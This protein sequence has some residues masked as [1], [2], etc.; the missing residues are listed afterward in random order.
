MDYSECETKVS[1]IIPVY[2][3]SKY[4]DKCLDSVLNQTYQNLEIVIVDDGSTDGSGAICDE[5]ALKDKRISVYHQDNKGVSSARNYALNIISG[6]YV[7]IID[8]DDY[9]SKNYVEAMLT[10]ALNNQLDFVCCGVYALEKE[11]GTCQFVKKSRDDQIKNRLETIELLFSQHGFNGWGVNKLYKTEIL[12]T[13]NIRYRED[14]RF[15]EDEVFCLEYII[16][17]S[18][19]RYIKDVLYHY[20]LNLSSVNHRMYQERK[21]NYNALDRLKA[22]EICWKIV[23]NIHN[24]RLTNIFKCRR[25]KSNVITVDK[26]IRNYNGDYKT[27]SMLKSNLRKYLVYYLL[28]E[29]TNIVRKIGAIVLAFFPSLYYSINKKRCK[30]LYK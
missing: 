16:H 15:C 1:I 25:Y 30:V 5:Y 20:M 7:C 2:N 11:D 9:L 22:D 6:K 8:S 14:L 19:S 3:V 13:Y 28:Y 18:K 21:F 10:S 12:Q 23:R 27:L 29:D 26:L 24:R 4:L 17:I